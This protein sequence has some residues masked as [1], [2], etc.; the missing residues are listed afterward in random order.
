MGAPQKSTVPTT[1]S[2]T[3]PS[4]TKRKQPH[5]SASNNDD[6]KTPTKKQR[7]SQPKE[8]KR[9]R[10]FRPKPPQSFH[11][12][13]ARALTQRFFVLS[14]HRTTPSSLEFSPPSETIELTGSTGNIYTILISLLPTCTCPHFARTNQQC[15]HIIY[16]LSRVLRCPAHLVYQLAFLTTELNQIFAGAPPIVSG[17]ANNNNNNNE[18]DGKRKPVE[19]DCPICFEELDTATKKEEIVWCKA[20][21]GQ[22]VHKQCF[23]MWAA[24]KRGQGRGEV[25]CPYC[26]SVWEKESEREMMKKVNREKGKRSADGG[27]YV[28]VAEQLGISPVRDTSS[29][30]RWWSGHPSGYRDSYYY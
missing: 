8:E 23:D 14:R 19:G 12:L 27:G 3:T 28:N 18:E 16:V 15:K 11:D 26:R 7:L 5:A 21:C 4:S 22:N 29:Y 25:T 24:T 10:R 2:T 17:S 9:L 6:S 20:A 1:S 30:S 13:Y